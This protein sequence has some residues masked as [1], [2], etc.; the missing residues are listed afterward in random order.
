ME[1]A[2]FIRVRNIYT[3]CPVRARENPKSVEE[4]VCPE[5]YRWCKALKKS[6]SQPTPTI[7]WIMDIGNEI[8][9]PLMQVPGIRAI[10]STANTTPSIAPATG[11]KAAT[12][13]GNASVINQLAT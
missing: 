12:K 2:K 11:Q 5:N 7:S 6:N 1:I 13:N 4:S 10:H 8:K 9:T 3:T